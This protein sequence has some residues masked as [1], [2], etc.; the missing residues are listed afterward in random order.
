M[1]PIWSIPEAAKNSAGHA[2][3]HYPMLENFVD[4]L[5]GK[6]PLLSSGATALWTDW[7]TQQ[8]QG[9]L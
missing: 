7:V 4:A 8:L 3:L 1:A 9:V 5:E 6:A 2:N